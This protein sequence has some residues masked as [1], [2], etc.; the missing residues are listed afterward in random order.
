MD[1]ELYAKRPQALFLLENARNN[2]AND[3]KC[4]A[5]LS[6]KHRMLQK[7]SQDSDASRLPILITSEVIKPLLGRAR[8]TVPRES[9]RSRR[10]HAVRVERETTID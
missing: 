1:D 7:L 5:C 10:A 4:D 3:E 2:E 9:S 8:E 6:C